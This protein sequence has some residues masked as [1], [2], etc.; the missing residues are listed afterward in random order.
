MTSVEIRVWTIAC[1]SPGCPAIATGADGDPWPAGWDT[2]FADDDALAPRDAIRHA[3]PRHALRPASHV[4]GPTC[5]HQWF[6]PMPWPASSCEQ[7][8]RQRRRRPA[9]RLGRRPAA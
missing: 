5:Q 1:D 3:C 7:C 2:Y 6:S 4:T 8:T 9:L